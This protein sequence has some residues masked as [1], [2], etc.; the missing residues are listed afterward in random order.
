[1]QPASMPIQLI[2]FRQVKYELMQPAVSL[3]GSMRPG[4]RPSGVL[5]GF[6]V[7]CVIVVVYS[8]DCCRSV[9]LLCLRI[10]AILAPSPP[11]RFVLGQGKYSLG[12]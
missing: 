5:Q 2:S 12:E 4:G 10:I 6:M 7:H 11:S 1:M 9:A 8:A 3:F